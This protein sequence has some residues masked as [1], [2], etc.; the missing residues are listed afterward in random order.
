MEKLFKR[1]DAFRSSDKTQQTGAQDIFTNPLNIVTRQLLHE[2]PFVRY[3]EWGSLDPDSMKNAVSR[4][5]RAAVAKEVA[6]MPHH[7][8]ARSLLKELPFA[9]DPLPS[10]ASGTRPCW[11]PPVLDYTWYEQLLQG[12]K[13]ITARDGKAEIVWRSEVMD[14]SIE[15]RLLTRYW[16]FA[17]DAW[18]AAGGCQEQRF[19]NSL[20]QALGQDIGEFGDE[21]DEILRRHGKSKDDWRDMFQRITETAQEKDPV[22]EFESWR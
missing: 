11:E 3:H 7:I 16:L 9:W 6:S 1:L 21:Y 17:L 18:K 5:R 13:E 14:Y 19:W 22:F 12:D 10:P 20:S 15:A 2:L 4:A 8:H